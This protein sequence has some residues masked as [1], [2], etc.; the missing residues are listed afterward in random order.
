[1]AEARVQ[2]WF[3]SRRAK[4]RE[5]QKRI[6]QKLENSFREHPGFDWAQISQMAYA[7]HTNAAFVNNIAGNGNI[8]VA[9]VGDFMMARSSAFVITES[10]NQ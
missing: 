4:Y 2:V 3:Q 7:I 9:N 8:P 10:Q 5:E 1:M 6:E